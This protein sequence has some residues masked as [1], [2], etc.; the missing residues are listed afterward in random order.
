MRLQ[1]LDTTIHPQK[2]LNDDLTP[3]IVNRLRLNTLHTPKFDRT[4]LCP[5][6]H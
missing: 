3:S 1:L 2:N 6:T 4:E 5:P